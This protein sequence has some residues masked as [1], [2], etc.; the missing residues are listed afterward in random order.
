[1]KLRIILSPLEPYFFGND[2]SFTYGET[3]IQK[4]GG[5]FISSEYVP[6]QTTLFGVLRYLGIKSKSSD[7]KLTPADIDNIG[8]SSFNLTKSEPASFGKI[9]SISPLYLIDKEGNYLI[10]TPLDHKNYTHSGEKKEN[11][12]YSPFSNYT[13]LS[14]DKERS[15]L[16]PTDFHSKDHV[17]DSYMTIQGRKI[18]PKSEI[19]ERITRV[20]INKEKKEEAFFKKEYCFMQYNSFV[21]FADVADDFPDITDKIVFL[22]QGK[23]AFSVK[24]DSEKEP[25]IANVF[26]ENP[27][28]VAY[29]LSDIYIGSHKSSELYDCCKFCSTRVKSFRVFTTDYKNALEQKKR[30][31]RSEESISLIEAGSIFIQVDINKLDELTNNPT[32]Q[33]AGF[34]KLIF[35]GKK[36]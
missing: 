28:P 15:R 13:T 20:G 25:E 6:S 31:R 27:Y 4:S 24:V 30:F 14:V 11:K 36:Q 29:A 2:R 3:I 21:F 9:R 1:M 32:A 7:Y 35:G 12:F 8:E 16:F 22:G 19:F 10:K 26:N 34:N 18:I 5:Y 17:A 23:S 33:T